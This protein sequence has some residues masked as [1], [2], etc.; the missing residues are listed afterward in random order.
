MVRG[1]RRPQA[2]SRRSLHADRP[3]LHVCP[4]P[5]QKPDEPLA[6]LQ[7]YIPQVDVSNRIEA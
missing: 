4:K 7:S 5:Y 6:F 3:G 1:T 2:G